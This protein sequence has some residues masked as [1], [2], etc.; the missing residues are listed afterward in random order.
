MQA[1]TFSLS[2]VNGDSMATESI[3]GRTKRFGEASVLPAISRVPSHVLV[4]WPTRL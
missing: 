3:T 2:T 4:K 1:C